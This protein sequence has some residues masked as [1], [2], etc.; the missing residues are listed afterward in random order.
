[1]GVGAGSGCGRPI[2]RRDFVNGVAVGAAGIAASGGLPARALAAPPVTA[3]NYPPLRT[4]MRGS[5]P[6]SFEQA[7]VLRDGGHPGS[8]AAVDTGERYDLVIVGGGISGLAAA[9]F[10]RA[11]KP[12]AR[13]LILDNHDDFGGHAKRNEF[14]NAGGR[15]LL[16]N[17]GTLGIDSPRPY[18]AEADGLLKAIGIDVPAMKGVEKDDFYKSR[19]LGSG[20]FFDKETFGGDALVTGMHATSWAAALKTAPIDAAAQADI[21]RVESEAVGDVMP[22]LTSDQKKD[23]L[24][25][26]S[27]RA[28]L[29]DLARIGP[30][31]LAYF[32]PRTHGWW[33]VGIDAVSALDAAA[34]GFP[35]FK[36]LNLA[37][38][39]FPR[40]GYTPLG[41]AE[42]GGS[43][44]LHLPD[45]NAT[46]ARLLVRSLIPA[47]MPGRSAADSMLATVDYGAL[48][49]PGQPVRIRLSSIV[50]AAHHVGD[51]KAAREVAITY[52]AGTSLRT[53]HARDVVMASWNAMI[54]Y[55]VP[56]L[57]DTQKAALHA[58][59]KAPL[60]YTTVQ[61]ANWRAFDRL[62]V[63]RVSAPGCFFTG[64]GLNDV[65]DIGGYDTPRDPNQPTLIRMEYVP[66]QPGLPEED[67]NRAGRAKLLGTSF[68]TFEGHVRDL[69]G[70]ALAGGGFDAGRDITAITVNRWPHGYAPEY[71][72]LWEPL[73]PE[74][75]QPHVIAR[76]RFGRIAIANS[77]SGRAAYTS[78]AIDQAHRAV[79][80]LLG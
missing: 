61:L 19:G 30:V 56:E 28:Y 29:A 76:Q 57:P 75:E 52:V 41:Y 17:G 27:Y 2:T 5:H 68:E 13:I 26:I 47:T 7:H 51:P 50:T 33:G 72:P 44:T 67:Q 4:G 63:S 53:V 70:R 15:T 24:S 66:C 32:Q 79:T 22:G 74:A 36:G 59:V 3:A 12:D 80:E 58:L 31:A 16:M 8:G 69:L 71:N 48:D 14:R 37:E 62:K 49:R 23:R 43:Y 45:G 55:V 9:H 1:M 64:F 78:S 6:G 20:I 42:T 10:Y 60:V 46:V 73:L 21:A 39:G 38:G 11:A 25:R 77:D 35:G 18:S 40:M 54:P 65:D 34:M